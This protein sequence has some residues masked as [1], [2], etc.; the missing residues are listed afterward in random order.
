MLGMQR[1]GVVEVGNMDE[2]R[3]ISGGSKRISDN[4]SHMSFN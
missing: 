3:K 2:M 1:F 4:M